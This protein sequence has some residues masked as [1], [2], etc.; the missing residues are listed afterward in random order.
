[1]NFDPA[2]FVV[3]GSDDPRTAAGQLSTF[4]RVVHV[5]DA[6]YSARPGAEFGSPAAMGEGDAG[7]R[8]CLQELLATGF[9]GPLLIELSRREAG[10]VGVRGALRTAGSW[11]SG[12]C[13]VDMGKP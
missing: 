10:I 1:V 2:N 5:K 12:P 3:Y 4:V 7:L 13:P 8:E 6:R 9:R 11:P